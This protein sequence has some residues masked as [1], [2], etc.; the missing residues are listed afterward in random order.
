MAERPDHGSGDDPAWWQ[1]REQA[2]KL[3]F[4]ELRNDELRRILIPR[5]SVNRLS[6]YSA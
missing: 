3:N 4:V 5:T 1:A 2:Y 6:A